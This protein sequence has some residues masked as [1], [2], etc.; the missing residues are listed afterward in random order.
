MGALPEKLAEKLGENVRFGTKVE[1][2][3]PL[4]RGHTET[5][6]GWRVC[7]SG[8]QEFAANAIVLAVPAYGAASLLAQSLPKLSAPLVAI[9][10]PPMTVVSS[11]YNRNQ[12]RHPLDG[13]GFMV[14]SGEGLRTICTFW[15]SSLF[16]GRAPQ[17]QVLMT[18]FARGENTDA[19]TIEAENAKILG[20][21]GAPIDRSIWKY[22]HALPQYNVGHAGR[23]REIRDALSALPGLRLAGNYLTG[24]SVGECVESGFLA[25]EQLRAATFGTDAPNAWARV[26]EGAKT[27]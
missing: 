6:S 8:G 27:W 11:A 2:I 16:P 12:V 25:A 3:A 20:I 24:R 1:S 5:E 14:P 23:V 15:N 18:S 9:E 7:V 10:H 4:G 13:F 21:A 17:G 26:G 22:P 19:Q